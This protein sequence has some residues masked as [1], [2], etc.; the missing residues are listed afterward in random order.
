[1][2]AFTRNRVRPIWSEVSSFW[3]ISISDICGLYQ[4]LYFYQ[5][6]L[7]YIARCSKRLGCWQRQ[8]HAFTEDDLFAIFWCVQRIRGF[9][10]DVLYKSTFYLHTYLLIYSV[11]ET[12]SLRYQF[13]VNQSYQ[14]GPIKTAPMCYFAYNTKIKTRIVKKIIMTLTDKIP[15]K[16]SNLNQNVKKICT[17]HLE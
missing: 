5:Y 7:Y 3:L 11:N 6:L 13:N 14:G 15:L 9:Y 17:T 12:G 1:M 10:D 8:I 2:K 16:R 4:R